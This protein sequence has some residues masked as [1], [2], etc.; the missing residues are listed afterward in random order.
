MN[1]V[2][3]VGHGSR[4]KDGV[5]QAKNF[6]AQAKEGIQYQIQETC[7][8]ELAEPDIL[9]GIKS[10]I[11]Q[12][13]TRI[14]VVPVLL[15]TAVHAKKDIPEVLEQAQ[16]LYPNVEIVYGRALG[17]HDKIIDSLLDRVLEQEAPGEDASALIIGRGSSDPDIKVA[18]HKIANKLHNKYPFK[19][20]DVCFMYGAKPGFTEGLNIQ[21]QK[22]HE[23]VFVIPYLLF[24]GILM[25]EITAEVQALNSEKQR[26]I[27]CD[28][29]GFHPNILTVLQDRAN[30]L[31]PALKA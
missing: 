23:Q 6:L 28:S 5:E 17:I 16:K 22:G 25:N 26:F 14:S 11:E 20:V 1:A 27:L 9:T 8:L 21:K 4:V 15:L 10:C 18:L 29:L 24:T 13:A 3:F 12:G 19:N 2:L 7:F 31:L 30:E